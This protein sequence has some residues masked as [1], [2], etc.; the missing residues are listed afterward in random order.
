MVNKHVYAFIFHKIPFLGEYEERGTKG[1]A[2]APGQ[3]AREGG[4]AAM[5]GAVGR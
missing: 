2:R 1:Q 3:E 4:K 5:R